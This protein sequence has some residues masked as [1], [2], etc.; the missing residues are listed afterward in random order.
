M[1]QR[2]K[3]LVR[4]RGLVAILIIFDPLRPEPNASDDDIIRSQTFPCA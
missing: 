4:P 1:K 3:I 2:W